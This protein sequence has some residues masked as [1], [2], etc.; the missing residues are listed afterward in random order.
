LCHEWDFANSDQI[1]RENVRS[2]WEKLKEQQ[3]MKIQW[4][5]HAI[6]ILVFATALLSVA[7]GGKSNLNLT[8]SGLPPVSQASELN[9][10]VGTQG[11]DPSTGDSGAVWQV[12]INHTTNS[13]SASD[14]ASQLVTANG[15]FAFDGGFLSFSQTNPSPAFQADGFTI[16]IPGRVAF[17]RPGFNSF[18]STQGIA[19][20]ASSPVALVPGNCLSLFNATF[21]FVTLPT[22]KWTASTDM[23]YGSVQVNSVQPTSS[24]NTWNFSNL[25]QF[26]LAKTQSQSGATLSNGI[27]AESAVGTVVS[28]PPSSSTGNTI[29]VAVGPSGFLIMNNGP[30]TS[31]EVGLIQ[32][33]N[34]LNTSSILNA[35][36]LGFISEPA[37]PIPLSG[38]PT[39]NQVAFFGCANSPCTASGT[40]LV[41]G[42]F[43][44]DDPTQPANT[45]ITINFGPQNT[46]NNG[47]FDSVTIT[48]LD[49]AN[50]CTS[51]GVVGQDSQGN[52]TCTV[53]A[54]AVAANP[55]NRF[56]IF[57]IAQ[58]VVNQSP[59]AIY[60][61]QE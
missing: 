29:T 32:P 19:T 48:I 40:S 24:G 22:S 11:T 27:C 15:L 25:A 26:T 58:D 20:S 10:Y 52:P 23:A 44:N 55:E 45:N 59:M 46:T 4:L 38:V 18:N 21:Q 31:G 30:N 33:S 34:P 54:A 1:R 53:P 7:C 9:S 14:Y 49:P 56:A 8:P 61:F 51:P 47:L 39:A 6:G 13:F 57:L 17:F 42:A 5:E 36:Y 3:S 12:T 41:G 50:A 16:E 43:P 2:C 37:I 60:L 28:I 35:N